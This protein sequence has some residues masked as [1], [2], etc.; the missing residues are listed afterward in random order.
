MR[1]I[2][3]EASKM[4]QIETPTESFVE[5]YPW[6]TQ[7]A[8]E[9]QRV[10]WPAEELGVEE[11]ENDF[12][13]SLNPSAKH[14]ASF[15]QSVLTKYEGVLGGDE[16]W[17]GVIAKM[18]PRPEIQRM[19]A[20]FSNVELGSHA[21]F[22]K[23]GN[24]VMGLAS[25]AFYS[26]WKADPVLS[27]RMAFLSKQ[28]QSKDP[29]LTTATLTFM[30]GGVL[31]SIFGFF[32]GFNSRGH[33]LIPHFVSGIDA[34]AK[35]ENFHSLASAML[36]N[37]CRQE[38]IEAGIHSPADDEQLHAQ[39]VEI[40]NTVYQH[41]LR[42]IDRLFELGENGI[43]AK[44]ELIEF[45]EDRINICL[46]RLGLP[47]MFEHGPGKVS[48]WFYAQLSKVKV[49]DFFAATQVQYTKNWAKHKLTF[50]GVEK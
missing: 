30:E 39:I 35:D 36:F 34:S 14:G 10:F 4:T 7:F 15:A 25:D 13:T 16:F 33:N 27:E 48:G 41:E 47:P 28:S 3:F 46:Q 38:R 23:I 50:R 1:W 37:T 29:L 8:L 9:Q 2:L 44:A 40:A 49:S 6:A 20:C 17:G 31:F 21:P 26:Q 22:Y 19:C 45:L 42:I 18:F 11:D 32:K 24:E 12:R 5:R 43:I